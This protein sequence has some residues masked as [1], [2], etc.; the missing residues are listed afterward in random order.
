M[1]EGIT[2]KVGSGKS[3]KAVV[4]MAAEFV[5]GGCCATNIELD[6][7]AI[8]RFCWKRGHRFRDDQYR[9][10][11]MRKDPCFHKNLPRGS[12]RTIRVYID[13]AHL[14][15][16]ASEYRDLKKAFLEVEAFVSQSRKVKVDIW[17]IT[18]AWENVWGQLRRQ[19]LFIY[20]CRD[21]RVV[22]FPVFGKIIGQ[23]MGLT[24][25]RLDAATN[26]VLETGRTA[27]AKDICQL[28]ATSQVYDDMMASLVGSMSLFEVERRPVGWFGRTFRNPPADGR[29]VE[30]SQ[31]LTAPSD[32]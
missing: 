30:I 8:A 5:A 10:L 28:Y 17:L 4:E 14:F 15:F 12:S 26:A 32:V 1:I 20:S 6:R 27:I 29:L 25:A 22:N 24:W 19:A 13:E 11:D 18:Q 21:M 31:I 16:P 3:L 2:G 9:F 23:M 7:D